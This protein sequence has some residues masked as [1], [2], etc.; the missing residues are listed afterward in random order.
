M[1]EQ[2]YYAHLH[3]FRPRFRF[4]VPLERHQAV[5]LDD[6]EG[7]YEMSAEVWVD[8]LRHKAALARPIL[9]P[10]RVIAH[11]FV[12]RSFCVVIMK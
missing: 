3:S 1:A 8:V 6:G 9:R 10:V 4:V 2:R 11:A 12:D 5:V 7:E